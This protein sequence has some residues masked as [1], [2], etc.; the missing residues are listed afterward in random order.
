MSK[1]DALFVHSGQDELVLDAVHAW[2]PDA[3]SPVDNGDEWIIDFPDGTCSLWKGDDAGRGVDGV[4]GPVR[5]VTV[6]RRDGATPAAL[7]LVAYLRGVG[8]QV[9][10]DPNDD[11]LLAA[12]A[13]AGI[14]VA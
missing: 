14:A 2:L 11:E 13:V 12:A 10:L 9:T 7:D 4:P 5:C 3:E 1:A 6:W 8:L